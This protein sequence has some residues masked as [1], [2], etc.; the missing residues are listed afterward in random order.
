MQEK[1]NIER[2]LNFY[3][4]ER[5]RKFAKSFSRHR[6]IKERKRPS[7]LKNTK[8]NLLKRFIFS[9]KEK[10]ATLQIV[11]YR[12]YDVESVIEEGVTSSVKNT[13]RKK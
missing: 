7:S 12:D 13:R 1:K 10:P 3:Q 9:T 8:N 11:D 6:N 4:K 2:L 5:N